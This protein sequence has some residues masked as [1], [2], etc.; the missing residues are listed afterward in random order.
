MMPAVV[1]APGDD[2]YAPGLATYVRLAP[3]GAPA[4]ELLARQREEMVSSL[5]R[6]SEAG[7][8]YRYAPGKWSVRGVLGHVVDSERVFAYR[9]L[10]VARGETAGLPGFDEDAYAA[11][12]GF[13]DLPFQGLLDDWVAVRNAS[14]ALVRR[15]PSSAFDRRGTANGHPISARALLYVMLGHVA[16]HRALLRDRYAL[17]I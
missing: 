16:H 12:A 7:A 4:V 6:L 10:C 1:S 2:E 3:T 17:S 5:A 9:L 8:G 14:I 13:D 15:L 11:T